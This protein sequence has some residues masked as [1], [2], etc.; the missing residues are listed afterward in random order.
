MEASDT[1]TKLKVVTVGYST[2]I[3]ESRD[4][5]HVEGVNPVVQQPAANAH[6]CTLRRRTQHGYPR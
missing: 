5:F 6:S 3:Y 1:L 2:V 4:P